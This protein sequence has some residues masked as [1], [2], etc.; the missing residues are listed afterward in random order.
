M[1]ALTCG[2]IGVAFERGQMSFAIADGFFDD[3][4]EEVVFKGLEH[5]GGSVL[6]LA[7]L[8]LSAEAVVGVGDEAVC[9]TAGDEAPCAV[10]LKLCFIAA[11]VNG[12]NASAQ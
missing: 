4:I 12:G 2:I 3:A 1:C 11:L 7:D 9:L 5:I 10:I 8:V 6:I